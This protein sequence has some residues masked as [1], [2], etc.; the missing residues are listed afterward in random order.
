[1]VSHKNG[2]PPKPK[3]DEKMMNFNLMNSRVFAG[4]YLVRV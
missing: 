4:V 2:N 3:Y 1:M